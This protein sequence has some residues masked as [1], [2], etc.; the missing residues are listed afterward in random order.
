[1]NMNSPVN[2]ETSSNRDSHMS[3]YTAMDKK[4]TASQG[5][6]RLGSG[7]GMSKRASLASA[8]TFGP[9]VHNFGIFNYQ[10]VHNFHDKNG[11]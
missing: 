6:L 4:C 10:Y 8:V 3:S 2:L 5:C 9:A 1:M 7:A 11:I